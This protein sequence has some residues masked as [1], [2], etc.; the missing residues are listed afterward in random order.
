MKETPIYCMFT[1]DKIMVLCCG[2]L[3]DGAL[4]QRDSQLGGIAQQCISGSDSFLVAL[5]NSFTIVIAIV[6]EGSW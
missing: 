4:G 1:A 3:G 5:S 2:T 6:I